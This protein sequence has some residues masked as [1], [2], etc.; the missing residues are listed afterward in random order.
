MS[1]AVTKVVRILDNE[2]QVRCAEDELDDLVASASDLD[3]RMRAIRDAGNVA[4]LDRLAIM[5]ALNIAHDN[6]RL[7]HR[8]DAA[9]QEVDHLTARLQNAIEQRRL[10]RGH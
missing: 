10:D 7:R 8:L 3:E 9:G 2:Y 5:A 6:L 1:V 4:G